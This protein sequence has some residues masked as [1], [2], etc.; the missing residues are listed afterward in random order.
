MGNQVIAKCREFSRVPSL[1]LPRTHQLI[2]R[3]YHW[4]I[5]FASLDF[6]FSRLRSMGLS[7]SY[8]HALNATRIRIYGRSVR[9]RGLGMVIRVKYIRKLI[10]DHL[11]R[12]T[13]DA[14][15]NSYPRGRKFAIR[16]RIQVWNIEVIW[17]L[18]T[19]S[20]YKSVVI[21]TNY[22]NTFKYVALSVKIIF[23]RSVTLVTRSYK[24]EVE[25][26]C[27][28]S[29]PLSIS[30]TEERISVEFT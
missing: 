8:L 12:V 14:W 5:S 21:Y 13:R 6:L 10:A 28:L 19:H 18:I 29:S 1:E 30:S 7:L 15:C 25:W 23:M 11:H 24:P 17:A 22:I 2:A 3:L 4:S 26:A 27:A 16:T 9:H 20:V